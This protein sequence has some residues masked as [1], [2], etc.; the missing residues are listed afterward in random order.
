MCRAQAGLDLFYSSH[1]VRLPP[2][3]ES[4]QLYTACSLSSAFYQQTAATD[5]AGGVRVNVKRLG[6]GL[7]VRKGGQGNRRR[8]ASVVRDEEEECDSEMKVSPC[9]AVRMMSWGVR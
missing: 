1:G 5:V 7:E 6:T 2:H 9:C 4:A 8:M 3:L